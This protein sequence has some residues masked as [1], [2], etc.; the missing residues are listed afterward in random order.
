MNY[1]ESSKTNFV[2]SRRKRVIAQNEYPNDYE[3]LAGLGSLRGKEVPI[4]PTV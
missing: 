2:I 4:Y 1:L 3:S